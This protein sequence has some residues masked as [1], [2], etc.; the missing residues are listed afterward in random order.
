MVSH[1]TQSTTLLAILSR[2]QVSK[3]VSSNHAFHLA[4]SQSASLVGGSSSKDDDPLKFF[5]GAVLLG[6]VLVL[7]SPCCLDFLPRVR[8][9]VSVLVLTE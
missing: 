4:P 9:R 6:T 2:C 7:P 5:C 3:C 8:L 1:V